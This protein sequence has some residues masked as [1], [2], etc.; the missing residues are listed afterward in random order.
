MISASDFGQTMARRSR[1]IRLL[2]RIPTAPARTSATAGNT[3]SPRI[4]AR[5]PVELPEFFVRML[6]DEGDL[7]IDP[8]AGSCVTGEVCERLGREWICV[9]LR[10][11]YLKGAFGRFGKDNAAVQL[12]GHRGVHPSQLANGPRDYYQ[13]SPPGA[14]WNGRTEGDCCASR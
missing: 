5:F 6:T 10:E 8:F 11:D 12:N 2:S 1:P 7:V 3:T 13:L 14:L 4:P 9:E